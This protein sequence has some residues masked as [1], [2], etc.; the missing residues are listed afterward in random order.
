MGGRASCLCS[1][2][3]PY[4]PPRPYGSLRP[5]ASAWATD[6]PIRPSGASCVGSPS[7]RCAPCSCSRSGPPG[8]PRR[9][10]PTSRC[11][12]WPSTER[13]SGSDATRPTATASS[14]RK[15]TAP[16]FTC[17]CSERSSAVSHKSQSMV[18]GP[19]GRWR[20]HGSSNYRRVRLRRRSLPAPTCSSR[21]WIVAYGTWH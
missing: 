18:A 1:G 5:S 10:S 13:R 20:C 21:P 8:A 14:R 3:A 7:T 16:A 2:L 19:D 15:A 4:A 17:G 12:W 6:C 9:C 11:P